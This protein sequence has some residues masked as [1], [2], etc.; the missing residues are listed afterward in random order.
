MEQHTQ[1]DTDTEMLLK[2]PFRYVI[3]KYSNIHYTNQ[4]CTSLTSWYTHRSKASNCY[5]NADDVNTKLVCSIFRWG[6]FHWTWQLIIH[7]ALRKLSWVFAARFVCSSIAAVNW[8]GNVLT[9]AIDYWYWKLKKNEKKNIWQ[10]WQNQ[11]ND[12]SEPTVVLIALGFCT[13]SMIQ[14]ID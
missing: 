9:I 12:D 11:F 4:I 14:T 8:Y 3:Y 1:I 6:Y 7:I 13:K 10:R 2:T 5:S